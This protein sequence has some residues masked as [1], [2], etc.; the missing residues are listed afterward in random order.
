MFN[1]P[2]IMAMNEVVIKNF[3]SLRS[4]KICR[5]LLGLKVK[6]TKKIMRYHPQN[7]AKKIDM[8]SIMKVLFM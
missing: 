3:S 6:I 1:K 4:K 8:F 5:I 7:L 2:T